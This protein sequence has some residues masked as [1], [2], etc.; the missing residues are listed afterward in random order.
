MTLCDAF[1]SPDYFLFTLRAGKF[2][3]AREILIIRNIRPSLGDIGAVR[4]RSRCECRPFLLN[5]TKQTPRVALPENKISH[6]VFGPERYLGIYI[7]HGIIPPDH[8]LNISQVC[9]MCTIC[10]HVNWL[11]G[12]RMA[13]T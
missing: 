1:C 9:V 4:A 10:L 2:R 6:T 5:R 13:G 7:T 11:T 3:Q 8:E 12:R